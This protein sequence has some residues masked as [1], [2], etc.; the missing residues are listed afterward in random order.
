LLG[1]PDL[2]ATRGAPLLGEG[3]DPTQHGR[4]RF[5]HVPAP[6]LPAQEAA[7]ARRGRR[8]RVPAAALGRAAEAIRRPGTRFPPDP[9]SSRA[10][11]LLPL[12]RFLIVM[13]GCPVSVNF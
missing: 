12:L 4:R 10:I 6:D 9:V 13:D 8:G 5:Y 11:L 1:A 3:K 7:A 2:P